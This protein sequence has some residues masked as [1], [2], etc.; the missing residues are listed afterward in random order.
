MFVSPDFSKLPK[1]GNHSNTVVPVRRYNTVV[2][3]QPN[4]NDKHRLAVPSVSQHVSIIKA[5][6]LINAELKL[7][8]RHMHRRSQKLPLPESGSGNLGPKAQDCHSTRFER[9]GRA[10]AAFEASCCQHR[11]QGRPETKEQRRGPD[12]GS[13]QAQIDK[14]TG[15]DTT[16]LQ[17]QAQTRTRTRTRTQAQAQAQKDP[18]PDPDM[19]SRGSVRART[20][21]YTSTRIDQKK[22]RTHVSIFCTQTLDMQIFAHC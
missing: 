10:G 14:V 8:H 12:E 1:T 3:V 22:R 4:D 17:A 11:H 21:T 2:P 20:R 5:Q 7:S 6:G 19:H 15:I 16:Q 13:A 18:D 9:L